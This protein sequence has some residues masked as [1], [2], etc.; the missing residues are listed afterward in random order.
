APPPADGSPRDGS[1]PRDATPADAATPPDAALADGDGDG[2]PDDADNCVAAPNPTQR[3]ADGD[4]LGDAC[5]VGDADGDGVPDRDDPCPGVAGAVDDTDG[6]GFGD[7]CDVCPR[8]ADPDQADADGDGIGDRCEIPGDDDADGV[9]DRSDLCPRVA[10]PA[11]TDTDGDGRG[12]ACDVCPLVVD[13]DQADGD[14]DGLGDACDPCPVE[15]IGAADHTD[16][17]GDG[18]PVCA[19]DCDDDDAA[20]WLGSPELCDGADNDC[21]EGVDEGFP[22]L[23]EPCSGGLGLC[24]TPGVVVCAS[25]VSTRCNAVAPMGRLE[26]CTGIDDDCDGRVDEGQL[27]CCAPG[28]S[29]PCGIERGLCTRGRQIC[30]PAAGWAQCDG[31]GPEEEVCDGLDNDCDGVVDEGLAPIECGVGACR[32]AVPACLGGEPVACTDPLRGQAIETC[33]GIDD[34]CDGRVDETFDLQRDPAN[35]GGC[36]QPCA[37]TCADG[38]CDGVLRFSGIRQAVPDARTRSWEVCY[39]GDYEARD[40]VL[41]DAFLAACEGSHIMV[42]CRP[43]GAPNWALL[44][45]G[46]RDEVFR[47][48]G[49]AADAIHEHNGVGWY[50]NAASSIGFASPGAEVNR[51]TCDIAGA[52]DPTRLCWHMSGNRLTAGYRC[53]A[54]RSIFD[55]SYERRVWR[56]R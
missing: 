49:A 2:V 38:L 20:R 39:D 18:Q 30:G 34:D 13:P 37:G 5:D 16:A 46:E 51:V 42:G 7:A 44:A 19:G 11:Q 53:G 10:N 24:E 48:V 26:D 23:G 9:P 36:G 52:E 40:A 47:D 25:F 14:G 43:R 12:D 6:D 4:G 45:Q 54:V 29:R 28:T 55:D 32:H 1:P 8:D 21:D 50:Y 33:N 3:D 17:D 22:G 31:V 27:P 41:A 15:P 56:L 35:C